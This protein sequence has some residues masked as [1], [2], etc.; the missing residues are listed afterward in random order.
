MSG[1][2][3]RRTPG[4]SRVRIT[5]NARRPLVAALEFEL[6]RLESLP[7][8]ASLSLSF[9]ASA[10]GAFSGFPGRESLRSA[11][12][13]RALSSPSSETSDP[14]RLGS[15]GLGS[16]SGDSS[17]VASRDF[18]AEAG[19]CGLRGDARL[20]RRASST[21]GGIFRAP[22]CFGSRGV[23]TVETEPDCDRDGRGGASST[24]MSMLKP[25]TE[26]NAGRGSSTALALQLAAPILVAGLCATK[27]QR[28]S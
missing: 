7:S 12:R 27:C 9:A 25:A 14:L 2:K 10:P 4:G 22:W 15:A 21:D 24:G 1:H 6:S 26:V 23:P 11:N 18:F 20:E 8:A 5:P 16:A 13:G 3:L 19:D 17:G 28:A